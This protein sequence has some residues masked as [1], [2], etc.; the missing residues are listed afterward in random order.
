MA[1]AL[2]HRAHVA[3]ARPADQQPDARVAV[4]ER[5][6]PRQLS[7]H[8]V[9][10]ALPP[11]DRIDLLSPHPCRLR[12]RLRDTGGEGPP[13][14]LDPAGFDLEPC[15]GAV[16]A[17][18]QQ[19]LRAVVERG[20][21]IEPRDAARRASAPALA[22]ESDQN[23]GP[24]VALDEPR[25]DDAHHPR[26]P[27]LAGEHQPGGIRELLG[28][29]GACAFRAGEHLELDLAPLAVR[30]LE[31]GRDL[32]RPAV[33]RRE[34]QLDPRIRAVQA[35]GGVEPRCE[36]ERDIALVEPL[37][38]HRSGGHQRTQAGPGRSPRLGE[39]ATDQGPV[40][41]AQGDE[42][43]DGRQRHEI[44]LGRR[45]L[46]A[47]QGGRQLVGDA[48]GAEVGERVAR[49]LRV[50]DRARGQALARLVVVGD[51]HLEAGREGR[52]HLGHR[53]DAAVG[54]DEQ[55]GPPRGQLLD[56]S[57]REAVA[58]LE[59]A[60]DQPVTV[61]TVLPQGADE[62]GCGADAIDVVVTMDRDP[63]PGGDRRANSLGDLRHRVEQERV[64][65][66]GGL[67]ERPR[68]LRGAIAAADQRDRDRLG[69]LEGLHERPR[70]A[71][72]VRLERERGGGALRHGPRLRSA[73]DGILPTPFPPNVRRC[74]LWR[75]LRDVRCVVGAQASAGTCCSWRAPIA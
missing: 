38:D 54:R 66:V 33:V 8:V 61:G 16:A 39:P 65:V 14:G 46:W 3:E 10:E 31:L 64:V 23:D 4:A 74:T 43:G 17:V 36:P 32:G 53:P 48:G 5:R 42:V 11:D 49:H 21:Q 59:P 73:M 60:R 45:G 26:M 69:E 72:V 56:R 37:A 18:A 9:A 22:V 29:L 62:D 57:L 13:E 67:E 28:K 24:E 7:G 71:V 27:V 55:R 19:M 51:D 70:L 1:L 40:L 50:Q 68:L 6:Q 47:S 52:L 20:Q 44:E 30:P 15:S 35:P 75:A 34:H 63:A 12:Q 41:P 58:V 25:G 2:A